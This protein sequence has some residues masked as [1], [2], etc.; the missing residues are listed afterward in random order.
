VREPATTVVA[1]IESATVAAWRELLGIDA[2]APDESFF[3]WSDS[4]GAT[5]LVGRLRE[6]FAVVF[7]LARFY[8]DPTVRGCVAAIHEELAEDLAMLTGERDG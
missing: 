8:E 1:Q 5:R 7:P 4:L 6:T 2:I 3:T